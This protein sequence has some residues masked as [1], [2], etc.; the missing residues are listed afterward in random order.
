[1]KEKCN[2]YNLKYMDWMEKELNKGGFL[3]WIEDNYNSNDC[4][5]DLCVDKLNDIYESIYLYKENPKYLKISKEYY[6]VYEKE[7]LEKKLKG[8]LE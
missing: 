6:K 2:M 7:M 3:K 5:E 8:F 1:M 4:F